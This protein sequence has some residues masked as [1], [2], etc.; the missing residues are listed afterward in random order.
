MNKFATEFYVVCLWLL[1]G[2]ALY[3]LFAAWWPAQRAFWEGTWTGGLVVAFLAALIVIPA[4]AA[5]ET[6]WGRFAGFTKEL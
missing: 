2:E 5:L 6:K 1:S 3:S 4:A